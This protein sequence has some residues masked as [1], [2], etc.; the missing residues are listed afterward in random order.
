MPYSTAT[1]EQQGPV[2]PPGTFRNM[3]PVMT[4]IGKNRGSH[5]SP[6]TSATK[7]ILQRISILLLTLH[8]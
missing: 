5:M 4:P 1:S 3:H 2:P 8:T 6:P 7:H